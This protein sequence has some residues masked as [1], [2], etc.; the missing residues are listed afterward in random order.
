[1]D[2][3][4]YINLVCLL[5]LSIIVTSSFKK[6]WARVLLSTSFSIFIILE[7]ISY[8]IISKW[9]GIEFVTNF[10]L[11]LIEQFSNQF[12]VHFAFSLCVILVCLYLILK[13]STRFAKLSTV[14]KIV[15]LVITVGY[16]FLPN[17][18][19]AKIYEFIEIHVSQQTSNSDPHVNFL[20][21]KQYIAKAGKNI[22]YISVESLEKNFLHS[23]YGGVTPN[24]QKLS[25][26]F[27]IQSLKEDGAGSTFGSL[28]TLFTTVPARYPAVDD[29]HTI[30]LNSI[31]GFTVP[32]LGGVLKKAGYNLIYAL[33]DPEHSS[34]NNL[35]TSNYFDIK[36]EWENDGQFDTSKDLSLFNEVKFQIEKATLKSKPFAIFLSTIDTHFPEGT[37][38]QRMEKHL[39]KSIND[40]DNKLDFSIQAVDFL[41]GD[42]INHLRKL[43]LLKNTVFFIAPD[44][45]FMGHGKTVDKLIKIDP[46]RDLFLITNGFSNREDFRQTKMARI[47]L[48]T[49]GIESDVKFVSDYFGS[50]DNFFYYENAF[51]I[52]KSIVKKESWRRDLEFKIENRRLK[53][54]YKNKQLL[55]SKELDE[56][57]KYLDFILNKK[58]EFSEVLY[59]EKRLGFS[60][61]TAIRPLQLT[62]HLENLKFTEYYLG[63]YKNY[64][65]YK[66]I[67]KQKKFTISKKEID[68]FLEVY[69]AYIAHE[70]NT[71]SSIKVSPPNIVSIVS[72]NSESQK[73]LPTSAK[74]GDRNV[75]FSRGLNLIYPLKGDVVS[76]NFDV[77]SSDKEVKNFI[78]SIKRLRRNNENF[79]IFSHDLIKSQWYEESFL[80]ELYKLKLIKLSKT[81]ENDAYIAI[82]YDGHIDEYVNEN[83]ISI[84]APTF[85]SLKKQSVPFGSLSK[86][87]NRFI[88]HAGGE[89]NGKRYSNSLNALNNSYKNGF[90]L[91]ELDIIE[92]SD[93]YYVAGHDWINLKRDIAYPTDDETPLTLSEFRK[94]K[95]NGPLIQMDMDDINKWFQE[96]SDAILVT[97]KINEPKA[98]SSKFVD[99]DRLMMEL[100]S[101]EK[102]KEGID[103]GILAPMPTGALWGEISKD[104]NLVRNIKFIATSRQMPAVEIE[105]IRDK[106]IKIYAFHINFVK[107]ASELWVLCNEPEFFGLYA[108]NADIMNIDHECS[109]L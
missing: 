90:K 34:I 103:I 11:R 85:I 27:G 9:I 36:S 45:K 15:V 78:K 70:E 30:W 59:N 3:T 86:D 106:N 23:Y 82:S 93:G 31:T 37:Y 57:T 72:S 65:I 26:E 92:T 49:A 60:D 64:G 29:D 22:I 80:T 94:Y 44:H 101:K 5:L 10:E 54:F 91:F 62:I 19:F 14:L 18:T 77:F 6:E 104:E 84:S 97:D 52:N 75:T 28:Y 50:N 40:Y 56:N 96:H 53:I 46:K 74:I 83:S 12:K 2:F 105:Q 47:I 81:R 43:N 32:T 38:D 76:K 41:I 8:W 25:E 88:A 39:G 1:M 95:N 66:K 13:L 100:F 33:S 35:I 17:N 61:I 51:N 89:I 107:H 79:I 108:D 21:E 71:P 99:K 4:F 16:L 109:N 73:H 63:N 55:I 67:G 69:K 87:P 68:S 48:E 102:V 7:A 20:E 98:F 24:L 42:L 58:F